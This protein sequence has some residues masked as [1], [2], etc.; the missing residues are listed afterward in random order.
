MKIDSYDCFYAV[1]RVIVAPMMHL[2]ARYEVRG[3]PWRDIPSGPVIVVA[4]HASWFDPVVIAYSCP[5]QMTLLA[6]EELFNQTL[7]GVLF[8]WWK[9]IP[10]YRGKFDR[11]TLHSA[12]DALSRDSV[13]GV[14][15]EGSRSRDGNLQRGMSGAAFLALH[16]GAAIVPIGVSG[17]NGVCVVPRFWRRRRVVV[18]IGEPFHLSLDDRGMA[19][20]KKLKVLTDMIMERVA[21]LLPEDHRGV[22]GGIDDEKGNSESG[23]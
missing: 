1:S 5:R 20:K 15:P 4:N 6:K 3:F 2:W 23:D 21:Q 16:S 11:T 10:V 7:W 22:Y 19:P 13:L 14:F 8:R 17:S 18:N 9:A 12:L